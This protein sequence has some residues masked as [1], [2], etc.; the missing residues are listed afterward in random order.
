[1]TAVAPL[2]SLADIKRR[3]Q[4][5]AR[6]ILVAFHETPGFTPIERVVT[7][8]QSNAIAMTPWPGRTA[9]SWLYW[10][11]AADV[12]IDGPDTF[13]VCEDGKTILTYRFV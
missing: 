1:M 4:V 11:A 6:M 7:R 12:R 10:P 13:S 9:E 2:T 8:V 5:G 3:C